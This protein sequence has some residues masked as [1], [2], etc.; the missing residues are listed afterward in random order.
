MECSV[1]LARSAVG[2]KQ[3]VRWIRDSGN[4]DH[5]LFVSCISSVSLGRVRRRDGLPI[6]MNVWNP[7]SRTPAT[8]NCMYDGP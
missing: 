3:L 5:V 7:G 2:I 6:Y 4:I 8:I 1:W